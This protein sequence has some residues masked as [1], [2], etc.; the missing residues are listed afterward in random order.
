[1]YRV[2][3]E[4]KIDADFNEQ[5]HKVVR[6][7]FLRTVKCSVFCRNKIIAQQVALEK[8]VFD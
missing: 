2:D 7:N 5:Y 6:E 3:P 1:M 8:Q 4:M